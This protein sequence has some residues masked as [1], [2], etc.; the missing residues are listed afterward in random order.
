MIEKS[1]S[2]LLLCA[3]LALF[4]VVTRGADPVRH[5][6]LAV[7]ESRGQLHYVDQ[8]EPAK[9]WTLK[10]PGRYRDIQLIGNNQALLSTGNGFRVYD[11]ATREVVTEVADN[12]Y[13]GST[14]A[15]RTADGRTI[16]GCNQDGIAIFELDASN[17]LQRKA[18]F[19]DLKTLRLLRLTSTGTVL[20]GSNDR[21]IVEVDLDGTIVKR[22]PVTGCK[23]IY[24]V[25]RRPDGHYLIAS[26]Y[27]SFVGELDET[28]RLLQK[29]GGNPAPQGMFYQ[30]YAGM[31]AL[32]NGNIVVCNWTGHKPED[33]SKGDQLLEFN[34]KGELVWTWH[35]AERAG[36]LHGIIV[37]DGLDTGLLNDDINGVL[38]PVKAAK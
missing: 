6:F 17:T 29:Y 36:T 21:E 15:R 11:L 16:I 12:A 22:V 27:G 37:L 1:L 34:A 38:G 13:R 2:H 3:S 28:G 32:G 30:F 33:S 26:G 14:S 9:D 19:P 10:F 31:Q 20:F 8:F 4:T 7:D 23:H 24:Q 18:C 5:R 25:L 35:D